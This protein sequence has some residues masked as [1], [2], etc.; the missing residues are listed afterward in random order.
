MVQMVR[1]NSNLLENDDFFLSAI[2]GYCDTLISLSNEFASGQKNG[3]W[4]ITQLWSKIT[5]YRFNEVNER[6]KEHHTDSSL[7][8]FQLRNE[9]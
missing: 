4:S 2:F 1:F 8:P 9:K 6:K 3:V 7:I 5:F